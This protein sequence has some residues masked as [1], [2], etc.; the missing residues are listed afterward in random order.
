M[1][2]SWKIQSTVGPIVPKILHMRSQ[3]IA[4]QK[5]L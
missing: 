1:D 4:D 5:Y 3:P 2:K